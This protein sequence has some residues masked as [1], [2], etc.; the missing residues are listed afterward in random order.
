MIQSE[1]LLRVVAL[2]FSLNL[3]FIVSGIGIHDREI[4]LQL[5]PR[6]PGPPEAALFEMKQEGDALGKMP[7]SGRDL[8]AS[9]LGKRDCLN[10][11]YVE[12]VS[13]LFSPDDHILF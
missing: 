3:H 8:V 1:G 9:W 5:G 12:C 13:K 2:L 11:G 6:E 4:H 7:L 10:T